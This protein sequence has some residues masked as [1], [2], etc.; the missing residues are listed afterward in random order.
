MLKPAEG[1]SLCFLMH[2]MLWSAKTLCFW[3]FLH[4][5]AETFY[6]EKFLQLPGH[7][8]RIYEKYMKIL[9][10]SRSTSAM[11]DKKQDKTYNKHKETTGCGKPVLLKDLNSERNRLTAR[12][13]FSCRNYLRYVRISTTRVAKAIIRDNASKTVI[14]SPPLARE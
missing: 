14:T 11:F 12:R 5:S 1:F 6:F 4:S 3:E 2:F 7:Y 9:H 13:F 8:I 10:V